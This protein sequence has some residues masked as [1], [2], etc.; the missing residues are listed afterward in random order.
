MILATRK[1]VRGPVTERAATI[2][3]HV[4]RYLNKEKEKDREKEKVG[5]RP[6]KVNDN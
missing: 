5:N 6:A 2:K 1:A 4:L 3:A